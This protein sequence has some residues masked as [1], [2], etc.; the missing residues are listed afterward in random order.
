[1][2][3][4]VRRWLGKHHH[5][6]GCRRCGGTWNYKK[7]H[8]LAFDKGSGMGPLC[9]EC[10]TKTTT[11]QKKFYVR[12]LVDL[13]RRDDPTSNEYNGQTFES[14]LENAF[15]GIEWEERGVSSWHV[16]GSE[17]QR[18]LDGSTEVLVCN[19]PDCLWHKSDQRFYWNKNQWELRLEEA[20]K[21]AKQPESTTTR[22]S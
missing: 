11:E 6:G 5:Y 20:N 3:D 15:K 12:Q 8:D 13:W 2:F 19:N 22:P 17:P 7:S 14:I 18:R 4:F 9:Q 16:F 1:M 21:L 10:W